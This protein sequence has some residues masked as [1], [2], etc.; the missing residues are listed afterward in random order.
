VITFSVVTQNSQA[1]TAQ[2][3]NARKSEAV[4]TAVETIVA[5]TKPEIKTGDYNLSPEQDYYS[6][7]IPK[8]IGYQ[9][10]YT[11]F[12]DNPTNFF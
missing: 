11:V 3:E 5:N 7:K 6:G 10:K 4:K 12:I 1:L 8:I 9:M 2:Q